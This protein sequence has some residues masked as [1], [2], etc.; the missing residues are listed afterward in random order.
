[1]RTDPLMPINLGVREEGY[2]VAFS[3]TRLPR[4]GS[5]G[6]RCFLEDLEEEKP[7]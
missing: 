2:K 6:S 5:E 4:K 7:D 3:S 1:M